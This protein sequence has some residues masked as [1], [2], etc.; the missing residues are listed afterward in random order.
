M[1]RTELAEWLSKIE[2]DDALIE[3]IRRTTPL[4]ELSPDDAKYVIVKLV[5]VGA[6]A[7]LRLMMP[8]L[9]G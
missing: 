7:T 2:D 6:R 9:N 8:A 5:G 4:G 3:D 1:L